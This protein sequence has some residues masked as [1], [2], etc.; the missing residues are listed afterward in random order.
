MVAYGIPVGL[1]D[2]H[3]AMCESQAI[4]CVKRFAV[5]VV[6]VFVTTYLRAPNAED[7][8]RI[9]RRTRLVGF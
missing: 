7:T 6:R 9:W 8:A 3:L 1:V 2:D 5:A 4:E